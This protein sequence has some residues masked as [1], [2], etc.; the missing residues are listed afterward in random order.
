MKIMKAFGASYK[1][2][3]FKRKFGANCESFQDNAW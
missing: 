1:A 3:R 2:Y